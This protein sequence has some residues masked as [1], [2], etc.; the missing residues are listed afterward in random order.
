MKG[1]KAEK[2]EIKAQVCFFICPKSRLMGNFLFL[3]SGKNNQ[4]V[5]IWKRRE[6]LKSAACAGMAALCPTEVVLMKQPSEGFEAIPKE[7]AEWKEARMLRDTVTGRKTKRLTLKRQYNQQPTYHLNSGF[8]FDSR[9]LAF[10]TFNRQG[11]SAMAV[12][13]VGSGRLK[14]LKRASIGAEIDYRAGNDLAFLQNQLRLACSAGKRQLELY[15]LMEGRYKIL[16][17]DIGKDEV[18]GHPAGT[19]DGLYVVVPKMPKLEKG[20]DDL[21]SYSNCE[22][23]KIHQ[24]S[25]RVE[26]LLKDDFRNNHIIPNPVYPFLYLIDRDAPPK[27]NMGGDDGKT[28]RVWI[29]NERTRKLT[30]IEPRNANKF[31]IHSNWSHDGEYVYHQGLSANRRKEGLEGNPH[32]IGVA[33]RNGERLWEYEFDYMHYGHTSSHQSKPVII[34]GGLVTQDLVSYIHWQDTNPNGVPRIELMG[35]HH[36]DWH[37]GQ[38]SHPHMHHSPD[39]QWLS[40]NRGIQQQRS[41]I[42]LLFAR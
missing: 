41:D 42:Y 21:A 37:R 20:S 23:L 4:E 12:A 30:E 13:E 31:Q 26:T 2:N 14:I 8:S 18:L 9:Y 28:T 27:F 16:I 6:M 19:C 38:M 15:D 33:N 34:T 24:E 17:E 1:W 11:A 32:Y 40:Y 7:G 39:G 35:Q 5:I 22:Y 29:Y 10:V 3:E 25:G 36:S